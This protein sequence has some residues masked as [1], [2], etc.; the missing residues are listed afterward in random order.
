MEQETG[1]I[2]L[3]MGWGPFLVAYWIQNTKV[4]QELYRSLSQLLEFSIRHDTSDSG[5]HIQYIICIL[6]IVSSQPPPVPSPKWYEHAAGRSSPT[7]H[8]GYLGCEQGTGRP[9]RLCFPCT[10]GSYRGRVWRTP[11]GARPIPARVRILG[12]LHRRSR[13]IGCIERRGVRGG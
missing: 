13:C 10:P 6:L 5:I 11:S 9:A 4:I 2:L 12:S 1:T 7:P 8:A 3:D